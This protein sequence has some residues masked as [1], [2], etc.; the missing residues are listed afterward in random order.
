MLARVLQNRYIFV[1]ETKGRAWLR[2]KFEIG[3]IQWNKLVLSKTLRKTLRPFQ[4]SY[5]DERGLAECAEGLAWTKWRVE[6]KS[7]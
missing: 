5:P 3:S 2:N 1:I 4:I 6:D 7:L